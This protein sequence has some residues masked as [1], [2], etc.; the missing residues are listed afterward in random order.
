MF[1]EKCGTQLPDDAKFCTNCGINIVRES[2]KETIE[3]IPDIDIQLRVQ[4]SFKFGYK[5]ALILLIIEAFFIRLG[6]GLAKISIIVGLAIFL[7]MT[8]MFGGAIL[9]NAYI[10]KKQYNNSYYDFYKTKIVYKDKFMNVSE[11]EIK[12]KHI[13]EISIRQNFIQ[14]FFNIG[15]IVLVTS[16]EQGFIYIKDIENVYDIYNKVKE[17][18]NI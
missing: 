9:I 4:P 13:R 5:W 1:C 2:R 16:A 17:F 8:L 18:I 12:Y 7:G 6:M 3:I 14:K 11:T 15:N 10:D